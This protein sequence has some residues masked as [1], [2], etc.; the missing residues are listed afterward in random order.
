MI[1]KRGRIEVDHYRKLSHRASI[2]GKEPSPRVGSLKRWEKLD[3][4]GIHLEGRTEGLAWA[5]WVQVRIEN[6][7]GP[8]V[9][10]SEGFR[11]CGW[12]ES[13]T[14]GA[15]PAPVSDAPGVPGS[16]GKPVF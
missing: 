9:L 16:V 14:P 11:A 6:K 13:E 10:S 15:A 1:L 12:P 4:A 5:L 2:S 7:K 8:V 3:T